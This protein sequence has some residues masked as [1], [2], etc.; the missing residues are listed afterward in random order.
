MLSIIF[1]KSF[2]IGT[3]LMKSNQSLRKMITKTTI[4]RRKRKI[5]LEMKKNDKKKNLTMNDI[6]YDKS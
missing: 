1:I 3:K 2:I 4:D 6:Q 5:P